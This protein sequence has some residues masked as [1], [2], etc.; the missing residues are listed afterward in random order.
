MVYSIP[1]GGSSQ[2]YI[3][4]P[5]K[6]ESNQKKVNQNIELTLNFNTEIPLEIFPLILLWGIESNLHKKSL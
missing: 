6:N 4:N 2:I 3:T 1:F 5:F